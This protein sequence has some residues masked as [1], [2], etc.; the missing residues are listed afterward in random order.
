MDALSTKHK[1]FVKNEKGY[2]IADS[3]SI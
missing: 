2:L 1:I 3:H